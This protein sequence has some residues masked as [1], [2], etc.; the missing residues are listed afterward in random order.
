MP[1]SRYERI[2]NITVFVLILLL[3]FFQLEI[4]TNNPDSNVLAEPD[5]TDN[6]DNTMT[7]IWDFDDPAD[8]YLYNTTMNNG[9]V[10]LTLEKY[11]W[12][13]TTQNDFNYGTFVST[14]T[15]PMG[16]VILADEMKSVNLIKTGDFSLDQDWTY[17]SSNKVVSK[18]NNTGE[19]AELGYSYYTGDNIAH[20]IP[21]SGEDD[22]SVM[23]LILFGAYIIYDTLSNT[24]IGYDDFPVVQSARSFFYFDLS[25]IPSSATINNVSFYAKIQDDSSSPDHLIDIHALD[26]ARA[27]IDEDKKLYNDSWNGTVYIDDDDSLR[28][29]VP[30]VYHEWNLNQT[31]QAVKDLQANLSRGWFGIG[32]HEEGDD[33]ERALLNS[34][35]SS[36]DPQLNVSYTTTAPI[37]FNETV[38]VNQTFYKP[39]VTPNNSSAVNLSFDYIVEK[40]FNTSA[41]LIVKIDDIVIWKETVSSTTPLSTVLKDIGQYMTESRNYNISL[42]LHMEANSIA[43]LECVLKYDNVKITTLGHSWFG[44]YTSQVFNAGSQVFWDEISWNA[45]TPSETNFTIRTSTSLDNISWGDWSWEYSI[46]TGEPITTPIG[47][48]IK[49]TFNLS[50][51]NYTKTPVLSDVNISYKKYCWNGTIEMKDDLWVDNIRNWGVLKWEDQTNGQN[52]S[53]WYSIDKGTIWNQVPLNGNMSSVSIFTNRIRFRANFTTNNTTITPTLLKWNLTYKVSELADLVGW[54]DPGFGH[55]TSWFNFTLRY[56]DSENDTPMQLT[57]NITGGT[58][59]LGSWDLLNHSA[60]PNDLNYTDGKWYYYNVTGF[61]RGSNYTFH[62]AALDPIGIWSTSETYY[63]PVVINSAPRILTS[64]VHGAEEGIL[65][66]VDYEAE[67]LENDTLTWSLKRNATWLNLNPATGNLSGNPPSGER[68]IYW[69]NVTVNDGYGGSDWTN[70]TLVVGDTTPPI[71]DA[72]KDGM[73]YEDEPYHFDGTNSTDNSGILNFTW[74]FGDGSVGYGPQPEHVYTQKGVYLVALIA[75]DPLNNKD[76][77]LINISV[78][79]KPPVANAGEEITVNEGEPA[80]FD[81]SNS[82]DTYSDNSSLIFLWYFDDDDKYDGVGITTSH[83]WY[84]DDII[85]VRLKV[86]DNDGD[87]NISEVNVTVLNVNPTV[88]IGD[89]YTG[90]EGSEIIIIPLVYDPG[91]DTFEFRWDWDNNGIYDTNWSSN[92]VVRKKW[93]SVGN[94]TVKVEVHDGDGGYGIDT[95]KV[96]ITKAKERPEIKNLGSRKI[97]YGVPF[98]ID[99]SPYI[100]DEDTP[101]SELVVTTSDPAHVSVGGLKITL[102]YPEDWVDETVGVEVFVSDG[103]DEDSEFLTVLITENYPPTLKESIPDVQFNED[104]ELENAFNLND[105]FEDWDGDRLEFEP[106]YT[107]PNLFVIIHGDGQV[108]FRTSP[109]W[110]GNITVMFL[111]RDVPS[112][113]LD[114][115]EIF[116]SVISINDPPIALKQIRST[117]I[118]ENENWSIDLLGYFL[119]VDD[120]QLIYTCNHPEIKID[121]FNHTAIWVPGNKKELKGVVFTAS[122]GEH[123]LSLEPFDLRVLEQEPFPWLYTILAI[124]LALIL[125]ALVFAAYREIRYRYNIE[126][127]FLVDNAGVLLVHLSKGESK[128]IDAKLVSGML[129]AVQE[130]VRDSFRGNEEVENIEFDEG[131]LGK[132]E[133]GDFQIVIERGEYTFLSAVIAGY[134]NKE[135]T[136]LSAVI[137]GYDNKR[138]RKRMRD[139]VEE[140]EVKYSSVLADWDGDMARF[141]GAD[142]IVGRLLKGPSTVKEASDETVGG[143]ETSECGDLKE[144]NADELPHGDF[145][146]VPSYYDEVDK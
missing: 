118:G 61:A 54:V 140:F 132:L 62:F 75:R 58:S 33:T 51:A 56:S 31:G 99:L 74:Y 80:F 55:I 18:H 120:P 114:E 7:A 57:L 89:Y 68:G 107:E 79:N 82:F 85:S 77:D 52:I 67:D 143:V 76:I 39:N 10:N 4:V 24:E 49:Y 5:I 50:T 106:V 102:L 138:L 73:I 30:K 81:G 87:T 97:R 14:I 104:D 71:A 41:D 40:L 8:Y 103:T 29:G 35:E 25:S 137:A 126:E 101:L 133:Y 32:I 112:G 105:H 142:K 94:H 3:L 131:A 98:T 91:L 2:K 66:Y 96:N 92:F 128:A 59:Q 27:D 19:N 12:D 122:D 23:Y 129:T 136:F 69:V 111:A 116:V 36:F 63:A 88:D 110:A 108:D 44:N 86:I 141:E 84:D 20:L 9:E 117:N 1:M 21:V 121:Q 22:G 43:A 65:Y 6:G 134:D 38:Y 13:Q 127:V 145:G 124:I 125:G 119:D 17:T 144:D 45:S 26:L 53:Y 47:R 78:L 37:T 70:F 93:T 16:G 72:G 95:A 11:W 109:N 100:T 135:Y 42:Q 46:N 139:V 48:Y 60:D 34:V 123:S 130:F 83:T 146:D 15:T 115:D 28:N 90:P 113:A 64:N